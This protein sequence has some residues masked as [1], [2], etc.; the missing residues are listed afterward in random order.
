MTAYLSCLNQPLVK[1]AKLAK[2]DYWP[3]WPKEIIGQIGQMRL[4]AKLANTPFHQGPAQVLLTH[5]SS[6]LRELS[7]DCSFCPAFGEFQ[8]AKLP[9][10]PG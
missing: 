3:N 6:I 9:S 5:S 4:L 7:Q 1:L 2:R 10:A 8:P